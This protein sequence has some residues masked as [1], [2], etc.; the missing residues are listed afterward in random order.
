MAPF[1]AVLQ[2]HL[3]DGAPTT[4]VAP[5]LFDDSRS[6]YAEASVK[7][8]FRGDR[9]VLSVLEM[10]GVERGALRNAIGSLAEHEDAIRRAI[11]RTFTGF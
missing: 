6:A 10:A 11:D 2:S 1:V 7:L 8:T 4:L 5:L 9:Y 3:L